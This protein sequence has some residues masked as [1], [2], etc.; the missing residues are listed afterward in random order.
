M[1]LPIV[2]LLCFAAITSICLAVG[3]LV[4]DLVGADSRSGQATLLR[5]LPLARDEQPAVGVTGRLDAAL[6]RLVVESGLDWSVMAVALLFVAGGLLVGGAMWLWTQNVPA[7]A[8]GALIGMALPL[9]ILVV[10]RRRRINEIREQFPNMLDLLSRAVRAGESLDQAVA[11]AGQKGPEPLA[12][13]LRRCAR[14]LEMGLSMNAVMRALTFRLRLME[15][16]IFATTLAVHRQ[17]GGNLALTLERMAGVLRDRIA[18]HRQIRAA[19]AAGRFSAVMIGMAGP[20][21]FA[22]MF[23]FQYEYASRLV[24]MPLGQSLLAVAV[25]LEIVGLIWVVRLLDTD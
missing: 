19:T 22:Y 24:T 2:V 4:R 9:P 8:A 21:L 3:L 15:V 20:L 6:E 16:R 25:A 12:R 11:L 10:Y 23:I 17:T 18:Y 7:A 13:E 14:Q 1:E 5:R